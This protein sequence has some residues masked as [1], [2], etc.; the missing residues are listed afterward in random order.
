MSYTDIQIANTALSKLGDIRIT[1][2]SENSEA[3][4]KMNA[5]YAITRDDV[6]G[7][8]LWPFAKKQAILSRVLV[9]SKSLTG[10]TQAS[11]GVFTSA[12]HGLSDGTE[13]CITGVVGMTD[14]NGKS[15]LITSATTNTFQ[16]TDLNGVDVDTTDFDAYVSG[17]TFG[18]VAAAPAFNFLYRFTLPTDLIRL[19]LLNDNE[20]QLVEHEIFGSELYTNS[21]EAAI[22]YIYQVTDPASFTASFIELFALKLASDLAYPIARSRTGAVDLYTKFTQKLA[23]LSGISAQSRGSVHRAKQDGWVNGRLT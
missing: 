8:Y 6:L 3:A 1:S 10:I 14:L 15:F 20:L 7:L 9:S 22:V 4:K 18:E 11:P 2:F 21:I 17:G 23:N 13:I 19:F 12:L 5:I 16:L